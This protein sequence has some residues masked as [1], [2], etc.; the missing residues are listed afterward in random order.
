MF[1]LAIMVLITILSFESNAQTKND[2]L[3]VFADKT[4]KLDGKKLKYREVLTTPQDTAQPILVIYLHGGSGGGSD[5]KKQIKVPAV[6]KIYDYL[7]ANNV[8]AYFLVPQCPSNASWN[9]DA[10]LLGTVMHPGNASVAV[11]PRPV[12]VALMSHKKIAKRIISMSRLWPI[13][14]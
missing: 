9:G 13:T 12:S 1:S 11:A 2:L 10:P 7:N 8:K 4:V 3:E 6:G 14:M 5:N